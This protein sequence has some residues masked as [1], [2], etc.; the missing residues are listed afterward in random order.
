MATNI[1]ALEA[2][3]ADLDSAEAEI[4]VAACSAG[5][6][7]PHV[8]LAFA[9]I[10]GMFGPHAQICRLC[11]TV[12]LTASRLG[13]LLKDEVIAVKRRIAAAREHAT[14]RQAQTSELLRRK[15][16]KAKD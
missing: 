12:Y 8:P 6:G 9:E 2:Y 10:G 11:G 14:S 15:S 13:V 7:G 1:E 3:L 5:D 4:N 16:L